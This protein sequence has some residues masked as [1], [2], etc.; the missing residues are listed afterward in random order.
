ME[1]EE[2]ERQKERKKERKKMN[3]QTSTIRKQFKR[4][5]WICFINV[6]E[7]LLVCISIILS[8]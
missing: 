5:W 8:S 1:K 4:F 2:E 6:S 3:I 7:L